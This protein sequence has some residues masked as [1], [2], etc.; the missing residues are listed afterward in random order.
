M[1]ITAYVGET[2]Q[3][4]VTLRVGASIAESL[5]VSHPNEWSAPAQY[6]L[7]DQHGRVWTEGL[8]SHQPPRV[9]GSDYLYDYLIDFV[10]PDVTSGSYSLVLRRYMVSSTH[11]VDIEGMSRES[12][13]AENVLCLL[14]DSNIKWSLLDENPNAEVSWDLNYRRVDGVDTKITGGTDKHAN[15][16]DTLYLSSYALSPAT[17]GFSASL[18]P[19]TIIWNINDTPSILGNTTRKQSSSLFIINVSILTAVT[20]LKGFFDRL[21]QEARLP[22]LEYSSADYCLWLKQGMDMFNSSG[23]FTQFTMTNATG[24]I[25]HWW[26]ICSIISALRNMYLLEGQRSFSFSGQSVS[27]DVDITQYLQTLLSDL[28]GQW[29]SEKLSFKQQLKQYGLVSGT[30]DMSYAKHQ[31]GALG[32]TMNP[33]SNLG[34]FWSNRNMQGPFRFY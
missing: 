21:N 9:I 26:F 24:A 2:L 1:S 25:R 11:S 12:Y 17:E 19:H 33:A 32:I 22:S 3:E 18:N 8:L 4:T 10:V 15:G 13:G 30:G 16:S 31:V 34:G 27:L 20:E 29:D 28:Q 23:L 6:Q 7:I 14:S 5:E